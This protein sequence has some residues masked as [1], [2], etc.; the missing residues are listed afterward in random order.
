MTLILMTLSN[1]ALAACDPMEIALDGATTLGVRNLPAAITLVG[2]EGS[3]AVVARSEECGLRASRD[4]AHLFLSGRKVGAVTLEV[5]TSVVSVS[6]YG[7]RGAVHISDL[8]ARVAV[9]SG[10]GP[11]HVERVA[12]LRVGEVVGDVVAEDVSGDLIVDDES[13]LT[14]RST[15]PHAP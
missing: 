4:G 6:V 10:E 1:L 9:V 2:V 12:H 15:S 8:P 3:T 11:V 14:T 13:R 7:H 5:P